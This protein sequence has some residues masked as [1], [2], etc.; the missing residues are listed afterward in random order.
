MKPVL[1]FI[2]FAFV[3]IIGTLSHEAG[4]YLVCQYYHLPAHI[5]YASTQWDVDVLMRMKEQAIA[6]NISQ[7][8]MMLNG[9]LLAGPAETILTSI[10]GFAWLVR[11]SKHGEIDV[12]KPLHLIAIALALFCS[13]EVFNAA[14][15]IIKMLAFTN[16]EIISDEYR[17]LD[18]Y[19]IPQLPGQSLLIITCASA[20]VYICF[21]LVKKHRKALI[22]SGVAG[23]LAGYS[24]WMYWLGPLL[25]PN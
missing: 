14:V 16:S 11:L 21:V 15:A 8:D 22:L 25:L 6:G 5:A 2:A 13:R 12:Y 1:L 18:Y 10:I 23:S 9:I 3:A 19:N 24:M 17:I 20:C 7:F 4:H